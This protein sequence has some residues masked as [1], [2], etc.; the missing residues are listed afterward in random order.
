MAAMTT[1]MS[2]PK[3]RAL[4]PVAVVAVGVVAVAVAYWKVHHLGQG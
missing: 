1:L 4:A 2:R 3:Y